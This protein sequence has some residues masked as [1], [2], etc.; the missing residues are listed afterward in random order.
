MYSD[1]SNRPP[2][3]LLWTRRNYEVVDQL[4][5]QEAEQAELLSEASHE[6]LPVSNAAEEIKQIER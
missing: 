2:F 3:E 1:A 4:F 5:E 6:K